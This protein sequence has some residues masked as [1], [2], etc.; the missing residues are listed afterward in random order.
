M[1]LRLILEFTIDNRNII[2]LSILALPSAPTSSLTFRVTSM[3]LIS[4]SSVKARTPFVFASF[5]PEKAEMAVVRRLST[6]LSSASVEILSVSKSL[7]LVF[8]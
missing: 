8:V 6:E 7:G 1:F 4:S 5:S 2:R 3:F